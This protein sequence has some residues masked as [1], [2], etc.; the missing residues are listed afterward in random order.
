MR[1][2]NLMEKDMALAHFTTVKVASMLEIGSKTKC[3]A[4]AHSSILTKK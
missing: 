1:G 2:L 3:M 4:R